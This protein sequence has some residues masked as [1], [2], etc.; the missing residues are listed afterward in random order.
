MTGE[1]KRKTRKDGTCRQ[2]TEKKKNVIAET[3]VKPDEEVVEA[4]LKEKA[5]NDESMS[6]LLMSWSGMVAEKQMGWGVGAERT[7]GRRGEKGGKRR[8][9]PEV[10]SL[11]GWKKSEGI[12]IYRL[13]VKR[14]KGRRIAFYFLGALKKLDLKYDTGDYYQEV[15]I[16]VGN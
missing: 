15:S 4:E 7:N 9:S 3:G 6:T 13:V 5:K 12:S 14:E 10:R 1:K 8:G 11:I 2:R 16:K